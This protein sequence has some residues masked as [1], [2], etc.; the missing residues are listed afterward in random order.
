MRSIKLLL[1][2]LLCV[3]F[4]PLMAFAQKDYVITA[5][6]DTV[7]CKIKMDAFDHIYAYRVAKSDQ[8]VVIDHKNIKE[9]FLARDSG[10]YVF[11][12]MP[13]QMYPGYVKVLEKGHINLYEEVI[14]VA[15]FADAKSIY[16]YLSKGS[17]ALIQIKTQG[18]TDFNIGTQKDRTKALVDNISDC[19]YV[20]TELKYTDLDKNYDFDLVR[21]FIKM[22]NEKCPGK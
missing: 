14:N 1:V 4:L 2:P 15:T 18:A 19:E 16:W 17:G 22:Y 12:D 11:K 20:A 6:N 13:G 10:T 7:H 21:G 5:K 8:Y 3:A 9:V